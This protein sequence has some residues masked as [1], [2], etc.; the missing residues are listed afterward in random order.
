MSK[1]LR[2]SHFPQIPCNPFIVEVSSI[3]EA[4]KIFDVLANYDLFQYEN[5]IKPDYCNATVLEYWDKEEEEWLEWHDKEN[6][7][8]LDEYYRYVINQ[9][10][11]A[12]SNEFTTFQDEMASI[13]NPEYLLDDEFIN[14][15][16]KLV[17][18]Q[19][20]TPIKVGMTIQNFEDVMKQENILI[21]EGHKFNTTEQTEYIKEIQ[22][23]SKFKLKE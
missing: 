19:R 16:G 23:V 12:N 20:K 2:V 15:M 9:Q 21:D 5:K 6:N 7:Y 4:K 17:I 10:A 22:K 8:T 11:A 14:K 18:K 13:D 3:E 1:N